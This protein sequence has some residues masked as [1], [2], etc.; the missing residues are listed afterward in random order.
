[1]NL[2]INLVQSVFSNG[3]KTPLRKLLSNYLPEQLID[4][5]KK[6]FNVPTD[7]FKLSYNELTTKLLKN[8]N[9]KNYNNIEDFSE[10]DKNRIAL[11]LKIIE[12]FTNLNYLK[13]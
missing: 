8:T 10:K 13:L 5:G 1:M 4:K 9:Y 7:N 3:S 6:G 12:E 2:P 11:R